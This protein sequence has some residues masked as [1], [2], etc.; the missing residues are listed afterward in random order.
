MTW[1]NLRALA[2]GSVALT[3]G[4][5]PAYTSAA[6]TIRIGDIN[7]YKRLP[8][9]TVPYR[10][11]VELALEQIN[12]AGGVLGKPLE[13]ISRD[14]AGKPGEA[15]KIAEELV[16]KEKVALISGTLFSHIGLA[17]TSY[18]GKKKVLYIAAEPLAD[19]LVWGK[20]NRYT[21]RLRPSTYMQAAMLAEQ[22]A[23]NPAKRWATIA[24]NYAYGKDAVAAFKKV[25]KAKRPDVEFVAEQWPGL[26]KIDAGAEV[27]A[28]AAAKPDGIYNVTFGG[29][30]AKFVREGKLRGLF[31]NRLMVGLLTGEPEYLDPLKGEAPEGWLV[32]GY[33]WYDIKTPAHQA[34]LDAYQARF[35]DYPRI[36]SLVGY[37]TM[38]AIAAMLN[39]AGSTD[40]EAMVEAMKGLSFDAPSGPITFRAIDHQSTMGAY[41]GWTK[42]EGGKGK[43]INWAYENGADYLPSDDVVRQLRPGS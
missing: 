21:F 41:V 4:M 1:S 39:K 36:G 6:D 12:S 19:A 20:G 10:H 31:E 18:A 15:V 8:A 14:D 38:Q 16:S 28:L 27:Q 30:L 32:T 11:G 13:L 9:H 37:N 33:P 25:L 35:N 43:M 7:S 29:D 34:F 22:A 26:F 17:L 42:L 2:L 5:G 3:V 24:P 40:T 23:K